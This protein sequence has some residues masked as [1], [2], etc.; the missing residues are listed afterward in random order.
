MVPQV[1]DGL[2]VKP[3][4]VYV[5]CTVGEGGHTNAILANCDTVRVL[6]IDPAAAAL[7]IARDRLES[8]HD[9]VV[10]V[11]DWYTRLTEI[12]SVEGFSPADGVLL[13][14]G[15]SS[16]Q[17]NTASRGFSFSKP[18]PLDM[19]FDP[20]GDITAADLV[21]YKKVDELA[22]IIY[23]YGEERRSRR[24]ANAIANAR[25]ITKTDQLA[26]VIAKS[27]GRTKGRKAIH[28][29][30]RT[31]QALRI[32]VNDELNNVADG[33]DRAIEI[34]KPSGRLLVISYH[35]LEDRLVKQA[36]RAAA[37]DCICSP[38]TPVCACEHKPKVRI[39][40]KRVIKPSQEEVM[41]N[42]R[43]RSAKIR[44]VERV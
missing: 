22:D 5:D 44:I 40:N 27:V 17:L 13:D 16:L 7:Q 37:S 42:P 24:I 35:S 3:S 9:R 15:V 32:A 10:L 41:T 21:N 39:V 4:C 19:R 30:T 1:I 25:P 2:Q 23:K 14:L 12:A 26:T 8:H 36:F 38:E 31:F 18:G 6:G 33:L 34:L 43:S 20:N 29:A 28:P 11:Q